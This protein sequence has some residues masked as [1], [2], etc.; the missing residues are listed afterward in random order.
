MRIQL[1]NVRANS[2]RPLLAAV[3]V[4]AITFTLSCSSDDGNGGGGN[5]GGTSS[6]FRGS[7]SSSIAKSSSSAPAKCN[8]E[9]YNP[10]TQRCYNDVIETKCGNDWYDTANSNLRCQSSV[11]E[12]KCGTNNWYNASTQFCYNN[13]EIGDFCGINPQKSYDPDLYECKTGENG[14]YLKDGITDARDNNK[15][16]NAVLIGDQKWMAEDLN[17]EI[18][19]SKCYSNDCWNYGYASRLYNWSTAMNID[20]SCNNKKV[21]ECG[22][23]VSSPNHQGI[24]PEGWHLPT[25]AEWDKLQRYVDGTSGTKSPYESETAGKFL[26]ATNGLNVNGPGGTDNYGFSAHLRGYGDYPNANGIYNFY[27]FSYQGYWWSSTEDAYE[28]YRLYMNYRYDFSSTW[29]DSKVHLYSVRC[30]QD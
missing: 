10:L 22:A 20:V 2:I 16:Y 6:Y 17:Y 15:H 24:C 30:V 9:D 4:I 18:D 14:I 19:G 1:T 11:V 23:T 7:S 25:N 26:K 13:S 8:G 21:S 27:M 28:A 12:T 5:G 3:L 29:T